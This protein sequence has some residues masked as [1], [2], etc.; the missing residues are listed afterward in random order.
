MKSIL[1][2]IKKNQSLIAG[3]LAFGIIFASLIYYVF[4]NDNGNKQF[5]RFISI[6]DLIT[7]V[8]IV[9]S[10]IV[11]LFIY[12]A[13][14]S[15]IPTNCAIDFIN[16]MPDFIP[17]KHALQQHLLPLI[18]KKHKIIVLLNDV[19]RENYQSI[20]SQLAAYND[21]I[22]HKYKKFFSDMIEFYL[23]PKNEKNKKSLFNFL[24]S[25]KIEYYNYYI[26]ASVSS[27]FAEV[28][29][30]RDEMD[31]FTKENIK[32][33]GTLSSISQDIER[34]VNADNNIIRVF[35]PDYDEAKSAIDFLLA[36]IFSL[37][38]VN[39]DNSVNANII[40]LYNRTYGRAVAKQ[41]KYFF[42]KYI[43][44]FK[45]LIPKE[46]KLNINFISAEF[47]VNKSHLKVNQLDTTIK[48]LKEDAILE[49]ILEKIKDDNNYFF[50]V[51]Y[52]PNIS[53]ILKRLNNIISSECKHN[54]LICGTAS[55]NY[56]KETIIDTLK[57]SKKLSNEVFY[58]KLESYKVSNKTQNFQEIELSVKDS[59]KKVNKEIDIVKRILKIEKDEAKLNKIINNNKNYISLYTKTSLDI[60]RYS[61]K[62]DKDLLQSKKDILEENQRKYSNNKIKMNLL[63]N[64]DSINKY[65]P[66]RLV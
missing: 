21:Y 47:D 54:I 36:R 32:V 30:A 56:W 52:E 60:V 6:S 37:D 48:N 33:I 26:I 35:P 43:E 16:K 34:Y 17:F 19:N 18:K 9:L 22:N 49:D 62:E 28:I 27:I 3:L 23:V 1:I 51:A 11:A 15:V 61:I 64:G 39:R 40:I 55:M 5:N 58:L 31:D 13:N 42:D 53:F 44:K 46:S 24:T 10:L 25:L 41:S 8:L 57:N 2:K 45:L 65:T 66:S 20:V 7:S 29:K 14:K 50:I 38:F 59:I 12:L 63:V 4:F